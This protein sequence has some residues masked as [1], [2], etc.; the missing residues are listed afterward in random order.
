M[1]LSAALDTSTSKTP[2]CVVNSRDGFV[3][4]EASVATDPAIIFGALAPFLPRLDRVGHEAGSVVCAMAAPRAHGTWPA[5]GTIGDA[6]CGRGA[7][8]SAQQ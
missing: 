7:G 3:V 8:R 2:V 4:F 1:K 6:P 5:H